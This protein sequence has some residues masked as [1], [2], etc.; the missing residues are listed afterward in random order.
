MRPTKTVNDAITDRWQDSV[1][2]QRVAFPL[3]LERHR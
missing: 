3:P 1:N 2:A